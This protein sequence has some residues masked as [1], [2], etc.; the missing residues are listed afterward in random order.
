MSASYSS[1]QRIER[2]TLPKTNKG[3]NRTSPAELFGQTNDHAGLDAPSEA[4]ANTEE[5]AREEEGTREER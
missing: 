2:R 3:V 5:G 1:C 4:N